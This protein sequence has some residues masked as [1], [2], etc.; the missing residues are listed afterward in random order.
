MSVSPGE[1][2]GWRGRS[3]L[4]SPGGGGELE[5]LSVPPAPGSPL[6]PHAGL[7]PN[8]HRSSLLRPPQRRWLY[9]YKTPAIYIGLRE[10]TVTEGLLKYTDWFVGKL[11]E[12]EPT[13]FV[14]E[15]QVWRLKFQWELC[16]SQDLPQLNLQLCTYVHGSTYVLLIRLLKPHHLNQGGV[17]IT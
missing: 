6:P 14:S 10:G 9:T 7:R 11:K 17:E 5:G 13:P 16:N 3:L 8:Q 12:K 4:S 2:C 1:D 15:T